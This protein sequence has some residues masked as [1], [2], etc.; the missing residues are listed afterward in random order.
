MPS[1]C[2][3]DSRPLRLALKILPS[4]CFNHKNM[5]Y[6]YDHDDGLV[7]VASTDGL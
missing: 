4:A 6:Q 7:N 5:E 1:A 3:V 2:S